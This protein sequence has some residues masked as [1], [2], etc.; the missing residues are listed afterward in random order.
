MPWWGS[1]TGGV[2]RTD[3]SG[4]DAEIGGN[5]AETAGHMRPPFAPDNPAID[6]GDRFLLQ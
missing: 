1:L 2:G 4:V 6:G 5:G 3:P